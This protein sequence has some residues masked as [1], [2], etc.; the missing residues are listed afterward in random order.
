MNDSISQNFATDREVRD[1]LMCSKQKLSKPV[2]AEI[3]LARGIIY[4]PKTTREELVELISMLPF[5]HSEIID[6]IQRREHPRRADKTTSIVLQGD[7]AIEDIRAVITDYTGEVYGQEKVTT[8]RISNTVEVHV[9][10]DEIDYAKNRL[11][12]RQSHDIKIE[13][14]KQEDHTI[15]RLPAIEKGQLVVEN[16]IGK[17]ESRRKGTI[18][19][20]TIDLS[21]VRVADKRTLFFTNLISDLPEFRLRN[22]TSIRI[23]KF[24]IENIEE[25]FDLE[26]PEFESETGSLLAIVQNVVFSGENLTTSPEY[27]ELLHR[28]FYITGIR[29][30]SQQET[31]PFHLLQFEAQFEDTENCKDFKYDVRYCPRSSRNTYSMKF[32]RFQNEDA[33]Y[34]LE[35]IENI[36]QENF[37]T[38]TK[39]I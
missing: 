10:F 2:L 11:I 23:A 14:I 36:A 6:L 28:G 12:R 29:W 4:S 39:T 27:Q 8:Q 1:L 19:T 24:P 15:V 9:K 34:F 35:L 13:F 37:L 18:S 32:K 25:D 21:Q 20:L 16:L 17:I 33:G 26:D 7:I 30:Q 3:A 38:L 31:A 22:V 5:D